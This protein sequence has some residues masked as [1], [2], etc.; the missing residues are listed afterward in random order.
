MVTTMTIKNLRACKCDAKLNPY[1][2]SIMLAKPNLYFSFNIIYI[3]LSNI[4]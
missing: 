3:F 1:F 4:T 2:V